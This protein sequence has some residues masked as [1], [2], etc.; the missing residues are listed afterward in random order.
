MSRSSPLI[1]YFALLPAIAA[2]GCVGEIGDRT[3][4]EEPPSGTLACGLE[5][6][7]GPSPIRRMT[8][9]EYN[10]TV[11]DLLGETE[12]P[13]DTFGAEEEALGFN[14]NAAN[15]V[16]SVALAQK[17]MLA[18]E[19]IAERATEPLSKN[20]PCDP[21]EIGEDACA[22]QFIDSFGPRAFRRP[23]AEA[24]RQMMRDL[25]DIGKADGFREGIEMVIEAALQSPRFLYR[26]EFGVPDESGG[27]VARLDDWEMASRLS[28]F[29]WGSM[30]DEELFAAAAAGELH[31]PEQIEAQARRLLKD[32]RA[33]AAVENFHRQWL[34]YDRIA[35]VGKD[36]TLFP[37]WSTAVGDLMLEE[38]RSFLEY[39]VFDGGGDLQTLLGAPVTF[40]NQELAEFYGVDGVMGDAFQLVE[41]DPGERAG[42]LTMGTLLTINAH[43]NQTSPVHRGKLVREQF[44]CDIM[45]APPPDVDITV[46][47]PTPGSTAKELFAQH[48]EDPSCNGCHRL[49]DPIGFGF[50]NYDAVG[51]FR[52]T[53]NDEPIDATGEI[54]DSDIAG[55]FDGAVDLAGKMASS[56]EVE[57]CYAL[58]WFR[59]GYGRGESKDDDCTL[60]ALGT[61]F[62]ES[63]GDIGE[64]L[65]ALTQTDA[66]LY[67]PLSNIDGEEGGAP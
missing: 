12:S 38:T 52:T 36:A 11:Y 53:E 9:F 63:G 37:E 23:L 49:M 34:D 44:L 59:Y 27:G 25:F 45:P 18:A 15:L 4:S 57:Q 47:E 66:F 42:L 32:P 64:L 31:E 43:S 46:P 39:A 17:Y 3:A 56:G 7:T 58:M 6:M 21:V 20:V 67:R 5:V 41:V 28:Y 8:H 22:D 2:S 19:D 30:P 51:R 10:R 1:A 24:E 14:N 13:A 62:E 26:V 33:R 65:V 48:S 50:E 55:T 16:T 61:A 40:L 60:D 29:L 54:V 35:N